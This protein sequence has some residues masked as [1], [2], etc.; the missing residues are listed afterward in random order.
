MGEGMERMIFMAREKEAYR[1]NLERINEAYPDR[2]LLSVT[3][4]SKFVGRCRDWCKRN[5]PF[6]SNFISKATLA[7]E[8]S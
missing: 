3:D 7:R 5:Y 1:D 4:V 6:K 8:L 2:E